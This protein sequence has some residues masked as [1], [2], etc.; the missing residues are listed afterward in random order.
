M[1]C[2]RTDLGGFVE[3]A[4][5]HRLCYRLHEIDLAVGGALPWRLLDDH[6]AFE[7]HVLGQGDRLAQV[8]D[9]DDLLDG[10]GNLAAVGLCLGEVV[11]RRAHGIQRG[12]GVGSGI[13]LGVGAQR[14]GDER[15]RQPDREGKS[16][17]Q[18]WVLASR[19]TRLY[20]KRLAAAGLI[21]VVFP[22]IIVFIIVAALV[23]II[24]VLVVILVTVI[25]GN[26]R[27]WPGHWPRGGW[28]RL[29]RG[30][31]A[32]GSRGR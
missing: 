18:S 20:S 15:Q 11:Q 3:T 28:G 22:T 9:R 16:H 1:E 21:V 29:R 17:G 30:R 32:G 13:I 19:C 4:S 5:L 27:T 6:R 12:L 2:D 8:R 10:L 25:A 26:V 31:G 24:V 14:S 23:A 7:L